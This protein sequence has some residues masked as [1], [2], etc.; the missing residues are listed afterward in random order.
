MQKMAQFHSIHI[1][2]QYIRQYNIHWMFLN[3]FYCLFAV[4]TI[5][6]QFTVNALPVNVFFDCIS[7]KDFIIY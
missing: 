7:N 2:H 3:K 1:W 4:F 5:S 6:D